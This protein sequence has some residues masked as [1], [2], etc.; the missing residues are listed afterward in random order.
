MKRVADYAIV[1]DISSNSER[2]KIEKILKAYGFRI[3]KSVFECR[4]D[5]RLKLELIERLE[6]LEIS[7][8]FV[9]IYKQE[10]SWKN[11][12]IGNPKKKSI[13]NENAFVI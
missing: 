12:V 10:Y 7:T 6:G 13:D 5:K 8:G 2:R 3:Q 9:K 4:M 11:C 1:Y